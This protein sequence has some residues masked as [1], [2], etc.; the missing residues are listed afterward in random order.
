MGDEYAKELADE[1][2]VIDRIVDQAVAEHSLNQQGLE[3]AIRKGLLPGLFKLAGM[4]KAR[5][6]IESIIKITRVGI[7]R[8]EYR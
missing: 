4:D 3:A 1:A 5:E 8:G 7:S 2:L 6:I